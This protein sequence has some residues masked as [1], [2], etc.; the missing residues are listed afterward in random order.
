MLRDEPRCPLGKIRERGLFSTN[1]LVGLDPGWRESVV[2]QNPET[3]VPITSVWIVGQVLRFP[4]AAEV[5]ELAAL[6]RLTNRLF[7]PVLVTT[8]CPNL[9]AV[10]SHRHHGL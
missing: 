6:L 8:D 2:L 5:V 3:A 9:V 4:L 7:Q 10:A 1:R